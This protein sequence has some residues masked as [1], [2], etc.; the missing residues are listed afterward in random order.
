[1]TARGEEVKSDV[2]PLVRRAADEG[3]GVYVLLRVGAARKLLHP[4]EIRLLCPG[5]H[6]RVF[7]RRVAGEHA[8]GHVGGL[9]ERFHV[10]HRK[11]PERCEQRFQLLCVGVR[12]GGVAHLAADRRRALYHR[13]AQQR[14]DKAQLAPA[15]HR[16]GLEPLHVRPEALLRH[17]APPGHQ[18][19]A[20]QRCGEHP[21][22]AQ[23]EPPRALNLRQH[24]AVFALYHVPVVQ[25]P[26]ASRRGRG[27]G[28][29]AARDLG[30]PAAQLAA[31]FLQPP[32]LCAPAALALRGEQLRRGRGVFAELGKLN[33]YRGVHSII[34]WR[35][36]PLC[37]VGRGLLRPYTSIFPIRGSI[38]QCAAM[39]KR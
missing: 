22:R 10:Q 2:P 39:L 19:I 31:A 1:M 36:Y 23:P 12:V 34:H 3:A 20:A 21:V 9:D 8:V 24:T 7:A 6:A 38:M 15:Q 18:H 17:L 13:R 28:A 27:H 25:K 14:R 29:V 11:E 37:V 4:A 30:V 33:I 26:L 5:V 16:H 32:R 35:I